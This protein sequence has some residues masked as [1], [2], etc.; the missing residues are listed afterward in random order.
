[1]KYIVQRQSDVRGSQRIQSKT[2][3]LHEKFANETKEFKLKTELLLGHALAKSKLITA[4]IF[5]KLNYTPRS[6]KRI[7]KCA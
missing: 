2:A 1:V 5:D 6:P 3:S 7:G 4:E